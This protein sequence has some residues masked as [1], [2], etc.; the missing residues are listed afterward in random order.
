MSGA[1]TLSGPLL[2]VLRVAAVGLLGAA[3]W[4]QRRADKAGQDRDA[5]PD[6]GDGDEN[7]H[8]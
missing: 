6:K 4:F 7:P 5:G 2:W 8:S 1:E 3:L